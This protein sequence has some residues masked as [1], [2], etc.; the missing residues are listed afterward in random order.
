MSSSYTGVINYKNNFKFISPCDTGSCN[1]PQTAIALSETEYAA[2]LTFTNVNEDVTNPTYGIIWGVQGFDPTTA[3]TTVSPI[4]TSTY[5]ISSLSAE[6]SYDVY[7]YAICSG[8]DGR[9]VRYTF[10]TP[11]IPNCK[12]PVL[13]ESGYGASNI[14]YNTATISWRQ[15][16]DTPL[17]WTVR[18]AATDFNPSTAASSD[19]T[20][21]T[22]T[23][24]STSLTGLV[25]GTTYYVYV[26]AT[27][28]V[29]PVDESPWSEVYSF[30]TPTCVTPSN[31]SATDVTN[32]TAM[33]HWTES[34]D[35]TA[36]TL[37]YG[38]SGFDPDAAGTA[39]SCTGDSVELTGLDA[40]ESYDVYVM[41][42]CTA[43][44]ESDW[45][46]VVTFRTVCAYRDQTEVDGTVTYTMVSGSNPDLTLDEHG[47]IIY[48]DGGPSGNY[49]S[50]QNQ[51]L[52]IYPST[53]GSMVHLFDPDAS[54][55][56]NSWDYLIVYNGVGTSGTQL[57]EIRG[58]NQSLDVTSTDVTGAVTIYFRS[59]VSVVKSGWAISANELGPCQTSVTCFA[60]ASVNTTVSTD[61]TV[62]VTWTARTDLRPIVNNFELKYGLAGFDPKTSGTVVSNLNNVFNYNITDDLAANTEYD[63]YVRTVCDADNDDYSAWTKASFTTYPSCWAPTALTITGTTDTSVT[64][65]WM[66]NTP[67]A[68]TRWEVIYGIEGFDTSSVTPIET[69]N[70]TQFVV[71]GLR[72]S[73][74]YEFYVR[75]KCSDND[76]SDWSA[77]AT[78][79]T[80]CGIWQY[81]DMPLVEDFSGTGLPNCWILAGGTASVSSGRVNI[82]SN[83]SMVILPEMGFALD[84]IEMSIEAANYSG[85]TERSFQVGYLANVADTSTFTAVETITLNTASYN[86][87]EISFAGITNDT[88]RHIAI[89]GLMTGT[90]WAD[91]NVDNVIVK[92][93]EKTNLL[94][95]AGQTIAVCNEFVMPDTT[96]GGSYHNEL[97][98]TWVVRPAEAGKV[99]HLTGS[100]DLENGYDFLN[101]YRGAAVSANLLGRFTGTGDI[102]FVT[103]SNLWADSGYFTLV[104]TSDADNAF[105]YQG[106]KLLVS[107]ECPQPAADIIPETV[108]ANGTYTWRNG[109]TYTNNIVRSGLTYDA[110]AG[111][112]EA[113]LIKD[114][115]YTYTNVAGCDSVSYS[116]ALTLH[117]TYNLTYNAEICERDTFTF[118]GNEYTTSG[119]YTVALTSQNGADSTG[120]LNLQ[121]RPAP[122]AGIYYN[123]RV[124]TAIADYCDNADL[125]LLARSNNSNA[126]FLWE[127][128]STAASRVVNPHESNT[129]TVV[130]TE[131]VYGCTSTP[132]SVTVTTVP[133]PALSI[134]GDSAI[135]YGQSTT[136][137][138]ADANNVDATYRWS[139]GATTT[140]I[141]VNPTETTTYTVTATTAN[142]SACTATAQF[143]VTVN[144]LPVVAATASVSEIC[145]DSIVTLTATE[146]EGYSYSWNT[147]ATTAVTTLPAASTGAYTVTVTD[148]NGCVNDFTTTSVTVHPSYEVNDNLSV[149]YTHNPY[150]WGDMTIT[151][152]GS[153]DQNFTIAHGCDSLVHLTFTFEEMGIENSNI[154]RC[155]GST[156]TFENITRTATADTNLYYID[157]SGDC[158]VRYNLAVV[159]NPVKATTVEQTVCDTYTWA[160]SG[161]T[162]TT[163]GAYPVTLATT[164]NCDSVVTLNLTVNYQN[165]GVETVTACD[166]YVWDLN[167]V[168]YN[169]TTN[170]PTFTLQNQYGCDSVVTLD[171]TVNYRSYHE[172][173]HCVSDALTYTWDD[174]ETYSLDVAV[175]DSVE[176]VTGTNEYG[177]NE[178]ALLHLVMNPVRDTLNWVTDTVCDEYEINTVNINDNC[179]GEVVTTYLRESGDYQLRTRNLTTGNDEWT[180]LHL[181]VN[182]STYHTTVAEE[183]LPFEWMVNVGTETEPVYYPAATITEEMVAGASVYNM[184][185]EMPQQYT[186]GCSRI[187]VLRLTPKY[188]SVETIED[189]ICQNGS[190]IAENNTTYYGSDLQLGENLKIWD[191]ST[192]NA[193]G[194][195]L[196]KKV[197]L[198]VNPVYNINADLTFCENE[199]VFNETTSQYE[200][201][202]ADANHDGASV[203]LTIPGALNETPYANTVVANWTTALGCDSIVMINYTVNP[204]LYDNT[205]VADACHEYTWSENNHLFNEAGQFADTVVSTDEVTGCQVVKTLDLTVLGTAIGYSDT[206]VCTSYEYEGV[207]YRE[208]MT[209]EVRYEGTEPIVG[210][211]DSITR[212]TYNVLQ[213][214]LTEEYILTNAD[215]TWRNGTTYTASTDGV[216]YYETAAAGGCEDVYLLHLTM[217]DPIVICENSLPYT[218]TYGNSTFVIPA[219]AADNGQLGNGVDT[220]I[221]FTVLRNTA[222]TVN[223]TVCDSYTWTTGNAETYTTSGSY[224][225]TTTNAAGCDSV[226]TLA[227]TVNASTAETVTAT[228]CDSYTWS[229]GNGLT[230]DSTGVY[231]WTTTNVAGCDS[232]V[233]LNLTINVNA[234]VEIAETACVTYTWAQNGQTYTNNTDEPVVADYTYAYNDANGCTGDSTL[235]LT[236]NPTHA[237]SSTVV[238]NDAASYLYNGVMYTAPYDSTFSTTFTNQYGCD[239]IHT[240][241]LIIPIAD[242]IIEEHVEACGSYTWT[243]AGVDHTYEWMSQTDRMNHGMALYK[244][245]TFNQYVYTFPTDTTFDATTG[246]MLSVRVLYL[247]LL[248]STTSTESVNVP[249]SLGTYT[250]Y[251]VAGDL[252]NVAVATFNFGYADRGTVI[253][254]T[255]GVG[256]VVYCNDF[257]TYTIN[258]VDNYDTTEVYACADETSYSW[259]GTDYAIGTPGHTY[260]FSQ[261]ENAG[262]MNEQVHVL[263]LNQRAINAA[264]TTLTACDTYTWTD[265]DSLTYT[266]SGTYLYNYTDENQCAATKTLELTV[267]ASTHDVSTEVV[268]DTY[269]WTRNNQ[270]YTTTGVYTYD[271]TAA[272][273]CASTDTLHLTVNYNSNQATTVA[274]C[275]NY[276]W[277]STNYTAS[278]D[279]TYSYN[280]ANGCPSV[281]TLHLTINQSTNETVPM[282][283]CDS[284]EWNGTVYTANATPTHTYTSVA[285]CDSVVTLNLTVNYAT[286][287]TETM[288]QCDSYEW[289]GTTYTASGDYTYAYTNVIPGAA[290]GCPSVDTLH[291]TINVNTST[292]HDTITACDEYTWAVNSRLYNTSGNYTAKT[293]D[294]NGCGTTN[295]L[296]LTIN[297]SSSYD[298]V[299]FI[300][301]GSYR[302]YGQ[303]ATELFGEGVYNRSEHYTNAAGC[304]S[305]LNITFNVGSARLGVDNVVNCNQYTWRNGETYVWISETERDSNLNGDN[306]QPLYKTSN[307]TYIYYNPTFTV[308][309]ENDFDSI[310]MLA[311]TLTQSF[312]GNDEVTMNISDAMLTYGDST[313]Y[314]TSEA[315]LQQNFVNESREYEVHFGAVQY[316]DSIITLT[317]NLVNN[318]QEVTA[319]AA[320]IC[321]TEN[322]YTWRNHT[323]STATNDFDNAHTYYAYDTLASGII[324]YIT[325]N[326]HPIVY[327]TERRTACDSYTWNGTEYDSTTTNATAFFPNGSVYGCDS[328]VTLI[329]TIN[330]NTST[331]TTLAACETFTWTAANGGNGQTYTES[332]TYTYDYNT[333]AGC[334]STNTLELTINHNSS[335]TYTVDECDSYTWNATNG[336]EVNTYTASGVYT[337]NYLTADNCPSIDTLNL[338]IRKNS[339]TTYTVVACDTYTW[340]AENGGNG[341][342][343]TASNDYTFDYTADNGCP[344]TN[345]LKLTI[346]ENSSTGYTESACDS[347]TWH[348][349]V[350][351]VGGD[352]TYNYNDANNCPS[353]DTLHLTVN[354]STVN[355]ATVVECNSYTWTATDNTVVNTYTA[356]GAYEYTYSDVNGCTVTDSLYLTIGNGRAFGIAHVTYCG[357][358]TWVVEGETVAVLDE[359]VETSTTVTNPATGCDSTVFLYLTINP[360]TVTE[361]TICDNGSYTW[362]VNGTT[363]TTAGTYDES[364][365]DAN[366]NCVSNERLILT[367]NETKATA[368]TDQICLGNGYSANGFD[369]AATELASAGEY[370]FIDSLTT[371]LGCDSVV[372]LTLTVGD[373]ISNP[374][375]ATAC[376]SYDWNAGDGQTYTYTASGVYNS[377]AYANALGCTTVDVLTLTI[378]QNAGTEYTETVCDSYMWNGTQYT[379]TGDY[380]YD[381]TDGNGCASTDVLHLTVNNSVINNIEMTVCDSYKWE[382]GT[383]ET[384]TTSGVYTYNYET[385]DGCSGTDVLILTVN[386]NDNTDETVTAC[387]NYDWYGTTYTTSGEYTFTD[388][389]AAGCESVHT[390]ALTINYNSNSAETATSCGLY[391]WNGLACETTGDYT[392][393]YNAANGCP[394]VDTLHLT[395]NSPV[396]VTIDTT[397]CTA[398]TWNGINYDESDV[399]THTYTGANGCDSIEVINLTVNQTGSSTVTATACDSYFWTLNGDTYTTSGSY[400]AILEGEN[401]NGCDSIVTLLLTVNT[402]TSAAETVTACDSYTWNGSTYTTSGTQTYAYTSTTGCPSVDTLYLTINASTA[403]SETASACNYFVWNGSAY[404]ESGVY[405]HTFTNANGCDSV[406]TL[407]LTINTQVTN[408]VSATACDS[409]TWNGVVYTTSGSYTHTYSTAAGCDS[410]VTLVLTVNSNN[411]VATTATA[412]DSYTWNGTTYTTSGDY[413]YS[414]T[415]TN[416]CTG[417][418]TLH[419]TV[420]YNT[421]SAETVTACDSYTWNGTTYNQS[422]TFTYQYN[423][424]TSCPSVDTLYLTVNN[425]S[426]SSITASACGMYIWNGTAYTTS[427]NYTQTLTAAN[428]CDSVVTMAL[429]INTAVTNSITATVCGSYTWNN[430]TYTTSGNYTQNFTSAAGCDSIVTL[431]L[432]ISPAIN[433]TSTMTACD[434]YTWEGT[435]YTTSGAYPH[436]YTSASGCDSIVTLL[437]TINNST[438]HETAM[439]AC[440]SYTWNGTAYTTSGT[441]N[442]VSTGSNGCTHTEILNLTI[443]ASSAETETITACDSYT[444]NGVTYT[445]STDAPTMTL[446]NAA[447]C[448]SVVTLNLTVN[449]ST[450]TIEAVANCDSYTWNGNT[451]TESTVVTANAGTNAAGCDSTVTLHLTIHYSADTN[452]SIEVNSTDVPYY[453]NGQYLNETGDYEFNLTTE[454]GCDST[455]YLHFVVNP[456]GI[457]DVDVLNDVTVYPNPTRGQLTISAENVIKVEVLDIVGRTVATFENTNT[458]DI[459]NLGT[460]AYTLRIS[461][462]QG[463]TVRKVVKK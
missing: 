392:Y 306:V 386:Y 425:S 20:E 189:T 170:T 335:T 3:G 342:T 415:G 316:C 310:Y 113:D 441:Y 124:V 368:L 121:V 377:E 458:F 307:G 69:T 277:N 128:N 426:A 30:T 271:Y 7:V 177:C 6:T 193:A 19:Y 457:D 88:A 37:K 453:F 412:C 434:S 26:K 249:V 435:T 424:A 146:V 207:T 84:T 447:G 100:Y 1:A 443:N 321:V 195:P 33:I 370:T 301:D 300:S 229:T 225:W 366:G 315:A 217:V 330:H 133:V 416:G 439:T 21:L 345:T 320:D 308:E 15:P 365:T 375:E 372:T 356:S 461:L 364:T 380:T 266:T 397:V 203:V 27:C 390:I 296:T 423:S 148:Q 459:S 97:N 219:D 10:T 404:T 106:F 367:V 361:A 86:L 357:P 417:V 116:L 334:P 359:S 175:S 136:L 70:N 117:P 22:V 379:E 418:D 421:S 105:D 411:N 36:W 221:Y 302:Y 188:P 159:V 162:Y 396:T 448:D 325:V 140:S 319:D 25:A 242:Q 192:L 313:F 456:V 101:V 52:T 394:S 402:N 269:T 265:G 224:E 143:T 258:L 232:V 389:T 102:D 259:N 209:F 429:T 123:N 191:E 120:V 401:A 32:S 371:Y 89:R 125:T 267:N 431:T 61:N 260:F 282:T 173:F 138:L 130:A 288:T 13:S 353:V 251:G 223:E 246:A 182:T 58:S 272:N 200:V 160:V 95:D 295:T 352:Y 202:V 66:E 297:A 11:F 110:T 283:V 17:N 180:R 281:D 81:E 12:V 85:T 43:T 346:N 438:S 324:E 350:Y 238:V 381:Y 103:E 142:A 234:G 274:A 399:I 141:T 226:V 178:I 312:N 290:E 262:T 139:T 257:R 328:T 331:T 444:W 287:N 132:A 87:F 119:A 48:D 340:T 304:D 339:D 153:Y 199:F 436:T 213:N 45:S 329:L 398:F 360:Q 276:D 347:Y 157:N 41:S 114:V 311:L 215:Y 93:R 420:N 72:H 96:N 126:T 75:A 369:I 194:C 463:V 118:Y 363:Y 239:S 279:Y 344:S 149:C 94:A 354:N 263:K 433:T 460:G 245:V 181:T 127:D 446:T 299:L 395:V 243:I 155:E 222:E 333:A 237:T 9:M 332:G 323:I 40:D 270:T 407:N 68:A 218:A 227:L 233:T 348:G 422:G 62:A 241:H 164:K 59:D 228:A 99:A 65:S 451:Y 351:T 197:N 55:E 427:G 23:T 322:S 314:F 253:D 255:V 220:I 67:T 382:N 98:S 230:Y 235:H 284:M 18:Y 14:D 82:Y 211:C 46:S 16:G 196:T 74:K 413:T 293:N 376:D 2:T 77:V 112:T 150:T 53:N 171:L 56:G 250:I 156:Y 73:T 169:T 158:P 303:T 91:F 462:P 145:R 454:Y 349:T 64:L 42:N 248:E 205:V 216:Y 455:V 76:H 355:V 449:Y 28:S 185:Y 273:G 147:G 378:N 247:N 362:T 236:L 414:Y 358:Y 79:T 428:G 179:E 165:T 336:D 256:S 309:R 206:N 210:G 144:A 198:T 201:T 35:A 292:I 212:V 387:D 166:S 384:Y 240:L 204:T 134:S 406:A 338:T 63:V 31:V 104:M 373:I 450:N 111:T 122:S 214:T 151:A 47:A 107:C 337:Y 186:N 452:I 317:V 327:A 254:T 405:T 135:C 137:T 172:D 343:Y 383:G 294:A 305:T 393:A 50:S 60:P 187:E 419:L 341:E 289:N 24:A 49:S 291:L 163:S 5:T 318:Y 285:G 410:V 83:N 34:G 374:V 161:E 430:V 115:E 278:G 176:F 275:D 54:T 403:G 440:D 231:T 326:Q 280:A 409:Y 408:T 244:D 78:G 298:S 174:G 39:V 154:E 80:Q 208:T 442:F 92:L 108:E 190:W 168:T 400:T 286:H 264:T 129:Y 385:P 57:G 38:I 261:V 183:C 90:T 29:S 445:V 8:T 109:E 71:N 167:G 252:E 131:S 437:L 184:S 51:Y 432:T 391:V 4:S 268:C 44:D 152:N 388:T